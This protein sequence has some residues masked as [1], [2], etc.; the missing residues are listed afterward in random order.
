M[1][2]PLKRALSFIFSS[3]N[4]RERSKIQEG[5]ESLYDY[6]LRYIITNVIIIVGVIITL[7]LG[8]TVVSEGG[9]VQ[10]A[11][12]QYGL[13]SFLLLSFIL[14]RF[15]GGGSDLLYGFYGKLMPVLAL[16]ILYALMYY[17]GGTSGFVGIWVLVT[18]LIAIFTLGARNGTIFSA[19]MAVWIFAA[20]HIP[21]RPD[22]Y[23]YYEPA[24]EFRVFAAFFCI[25]ILGFVFEVT[26]L[27]SQKQI[28]RIVEELMQQNEEIE[29]QNNTILENQATERKLKSIMEVS[30][31]QF[32]MNLMENMESVI[33]LYEAIEK[34]GEVVDL[35]IVWVNQF[36]IDIVNKNTS[37]N[38]TLGDIAGKMFSE[39]TP[40]DKN[41]ISV[42]GAIATGKS[43]MQIT[44]SYSEYAKAYIRVQA[45]SP[46]PGKVATILQFRTKFVQSEIE[47]EQHEYWLRSIMQMLPDGILY[48]ELVYDEENNPIDFHVHYVNP[49][50]EMLEG[51]RVN[52]LQ[53][54]NIFEEYPNEPKDDL[55]KCQEAVENN[56]IVQRVLFDPWSRYMEMTFYPQGGKKLFVI[57]KDIT[58]KVK[59][60]NELKEAHKTIL[61]S[62]N[63]A[64]KIQG[65]LLPSESVFETAFSDYSVIWKPRDIVGGDIY[66]AK[67]FEDGTVL[68]VADCTGHGTPGALLTMLVV[69][70][71]ET[72][73]TEK[74]HTDMAEI[75][76]R[77]D[78]RI[79]SVLNVE[80]ERQGDT[81][82]NDG[83]DL[84]VLFIKKDGS[85]EFSSGNTNVFVCDGKEVVRHKGQKIF[86]GEGK[87]ASAADVNVINI[88]ANPDN[89]FYVASDGLYDQTNKDDIIFGTKKFSA[90]ILEN[91][92]EKQNIIT[93][94]VWNAFNEW[95]GEEPRL[96]D[97]NLVTFKPKN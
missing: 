26:R 90:I 49:A 96:D 5:K 2:N 58:E 48:G 62:I 71:F 13:A 53:G 24:V 68:C 44:E 34:D 83:C 59:A 9:T 17:R 51:L 77:L 38:L 1:Q 61:G 67:N 7:I 78:K 30:E 81:F 47:K 18:P 97:F 41:W 64:G 14:R 19:I 28:H 92:N 6:K 37:S 82:I 56:R 54:K 45:Y 25:W 73:I 95:Q 23:Y 15:W 52:S 65:N 33:A 21:G 29:A 88:P 35:R 40:D 39:V 57:H 22:H 55:I 42:Y 87:L 80:S 72:I 84:A 79:S 66:W 8:P 86:I 69:S 50:Y 43:E 20:N 4:Y 60:V 16:S 63:Y 3:D 12:V 89:K 85:V 11:I 36:Y 76:H 46:K 70:A 75:L 27:K 93:D 94:K 32:A 31:E 74:Y 10:L 91:H